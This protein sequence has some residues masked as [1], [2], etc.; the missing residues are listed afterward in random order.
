[1]SITLRLHQTSFSAYKKENMNKMLHLI[2]E[3]DAY[4]DVFPEYS[5][6]IPPTGLDKKF[7]YKNA[8]TIDG[9]FIHRM[10]E[11]TVERGSA[12]VFSA[13]LQEDGKVYN[14]AI[15]AE[16]GKIK[17][18]YR[19]IHLF[20]AFGYYE[21]EVFTWGRELAIADLKGF[22]IG[23]A[24]CFDLRFPELFRI[25][26]QRG[27]NLF[28]VP[29]AWYKGKHKISQW[30]ALTL[31]RSHENNSYLI[32][33]GQ[34]RP[35]FIGHSMATSPLG[36]VIKEVEEEQTSFTVNLEYQAIEESIRLL[37]IMTLSKPLLYKR[38][39]QQ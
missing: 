36:Y 2:E 13:Y 8:E 39:Y 14:A 20:D 29:S 6:G 33:V 26:A 18:V 11:K 37:P 16:K 9:Q 5:M 22:K 24:V 35:F 30:Q 32:A 1:M 10:I 17:T 12:I 31:A 15:L 38:Y 19:K 34:T 4:I 23:L 25:M 3:S 28:I 7:V 21:S 27:V